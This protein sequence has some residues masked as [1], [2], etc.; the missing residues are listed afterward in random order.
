MEEVLKHSLLAFIKSSFNDG[1]ETVHTQAFSMFVDAADSGE[2]VSLIGSCPLKEHNLVG[3]AGSKDASVRQAVYASKSIS[4]EKLVELAKK[5]KSSKVLSQLIGSL[6]EQSYMDLISK[7]GFARDYLQAAFENKEG[8][9]YLKDT[10]SLKTLINVVFSYPESRGISTDELHGLVKVI[11]R[12]DSSDVW[13][14]VYQYLLS[15]GFKNYLDTFSRLDAAKSMDMV[16]L[17]Y[18]THQSLSAPVAVSVDGFGNILEE[19]F[20]DMVSTTL[21]LRFGGHRSFSSFYAVRQ[22]GDAVYRD[23]FNLLEKL[24][25]NP[26]IPV[27]VQQSACSVFKEAL[28]LMASSTHKSF[29][30]TPKM[31]GLVASWEESQKS[32]GSATAD[33]VDGILNSDPCTSAYLESTTVEYRWTVFSKVFE[34]LESQGR[35]SNIELTDRVFET[36]YSIGTEG[37]VSD[38]VSKL[39]LENPRNS[40]GYSY[41]RSPFVV[42][43]MCRVANDVEVSSNKYFLRAMTSVLARSFSNVQFPNAAAMCSTIEVASFVAQLV[44]SFPEDSTRSRP[45]GVTTQ[46]L[47]EKFPELISPKDFYTAVK[48]KNGY[49]HYANGA[50]EFPNFNR[51]FVSALVELSASHGTLFLELAPSWSG[52]LTELVS[53]V[54]DTA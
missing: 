5:E 16:S 7:K 32:S 27:E 47:D 9:V 15:D 4:K 22:L 18:L 8:L 45:G 14:D 37:E 36:L 20:D 29:P 39:I 38:L 44:K 24:L 51:M 43:V 23:F 49:Y 52:S 13:M 19:F 54:N 3:L 30:I 40:S 12:I 34:T 35:S 17:R 53:T 1:D 21:T 33:V 10:E 26:S 41:D 42:T 46:A 6:P 31:K 48:S 25:E 50:A 2:I 11:K 28:D